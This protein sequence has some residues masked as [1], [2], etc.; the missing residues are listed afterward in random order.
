ME[1]MRSLMRAN[2][3]DVRGNVLVAGACLP[4]TAPEALAALAE[5][6]DDILTVCPE[7]THINMI[8]TKLSAMLGTGRLERLRFV[9]VDRS[10]HCVQLHYIRHEIERILPE[11]V[12]MESLIAIGKEI[13]P[14]L[15]EAAEL[16]KSLFR[17]SRLVEEGRITP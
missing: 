10:P 9:T 15:P 12:P 5:D 8:V 11:H 1:R 6:A 13:F 7:E 2:V 4:G 17:L 14:V 3:Y 16:S